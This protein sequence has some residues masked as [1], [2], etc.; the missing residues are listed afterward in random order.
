M[1]CSASNSFYVAPHSNAI[2]TL[3]GKNFQ[4]QIFLRGP[5]TGNFA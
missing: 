2:Q 3:A 1:R 5:K 4:T